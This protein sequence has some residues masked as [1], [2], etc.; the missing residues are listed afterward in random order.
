MT[1]DIYD[2][3]CV[4]GFKYVGAI[5]TSEEDINF[6]L[7]FR[8]LND[9]KSFFTMWDIKQPMPMPMQIMGVQTPESCVEP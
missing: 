4:G 1:M 2:F 9:N 3:E 7:K 6:G 8:I 5:I